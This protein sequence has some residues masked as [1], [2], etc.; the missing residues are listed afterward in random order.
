MAKLELHWKNKILTNVGAIG[1]V[2]RSIKN[3]EVASAF[4]GAYLAADVYAVENL[5][6]IFL[7]MDPVVG[8]EKL[9]LFGLIERNKRKGDEI[10][11][12]V[13]SA[14]AEA[15]IEKNA[16]KHLEKVAEV[17]TEDKSEEAPAVEAK[18]P[19]LQLVPDKQKA[20][21]VLDF[22]IDCSICSSKYD[23]HHEGYTVNKEGVAACDECIDRAITLCTEALP[24]KEKGRGIPDADIVAMLKDMIPAVKKVKGVKSDLVDVIEIGDKVKTRDGSKGRVYKI[25]DGKAFIKIKSGDAIRKLKSSLTNLVIISKKVTVPPPAEFIEEFE[26]A[27][28]AEATSAE[29]EGEVASIVIEEQPAEVEELQFVITVSESDVK[30]LLKSAVK[31]SKSLLVGKEIKKHKRVEE[32]E[33]SVKSIYNSELLILLNARFQEARKELGKSSKPYV[34]AAKKAVAKHT[35]A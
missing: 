7:K 31:H 2:A 1:L 5:K 10:E 23:P 3:K 28:L 27:V 11:K 4:L 6:A 21:S 18:K 15:A 13:T 19:V 30:D 17:P 8:S 22:K 29:E 16:L 25:E 9:E 14:S 12:A 34:L 20:P 26:E 35:W 32:F 33:E 24:K